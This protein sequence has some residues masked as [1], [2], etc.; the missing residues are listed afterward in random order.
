MNQKKNGADHVH[1]VEVPSD[2]P[3][4][5]SKT[6]SRKNQEDKKL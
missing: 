1:E 6:L 3:I 2:H 4:Q 5:N